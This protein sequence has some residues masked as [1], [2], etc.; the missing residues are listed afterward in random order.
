MKR[1]GIGGL[2]NFDA[3]LAT[4]QVVHKRLAY[5]T[6]E[7]KDAFRFAASEA[8]RLGLELAIAASPG[9]SETGGPWVKPSDGMKK[10]VWSELEV[11]GGRPLASRLLPPPA[12][13]GPYQDLPIGEAGSSAAGKPHFK[14]PEA[15][16]DVAVLAFPVMPATDDMPLAIE[17]AGGEAF[18]LA[19]L[20]DDSL[21][22]GVDIPASA[23]GKTSYLTLTYDRPTTFRS[24]ELFAVGGMSLF[25]HSLIAPRLERSDDGK[26]WLPVA[27][28]P[29]GPVP[30]TVGFAP[31]SARFFRV[32]FALAAPDQRSL[33]SPAPGADLS[34]VRYLAPPPRTTFRV[35]TLR[36]SSAAKIDQ[37]QSKAGFRTVPDYYK[38]SETVPDEDG[39]HLDNIINLSDRLKPDGSLDWLPPEGNWRIVRLGWSLVGT[40]NHPATLEATG[41]EVDKYDGEAVRRYL[42]H[43]LGMYKDTVGA[44]LIGQS[45]VRALLTDSIEVGPSNWTPRLIEQFK[46]LRGYDPTPYLPALAGY[47]VQSRADSDKFLYDFRR[48]LADLIASE[49]Y[50]TVAQVARDNGM[51]VYGE[52]LEWERPLIVTCPPLA[53]SI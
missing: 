50:G 21:T 27:E 48:T 40:T 30:T 5:M 20:N 33:G 53:P 49:H 23:E 35:G 42:N 39:I 11:V 36:L 6:P 44:N 16:G 17:G 29:V 46:K 28:I 7:W 10:L 2:Q 37:F 45:G 26:S 12:V 22:T 14:A 38:L 41:L 15:Y 52:A 43:Y 18:D 9:W 3:D 25:R 4:P 24:I 13:A 34:G 51:I 31:V 1:I 8:D 47:I 19:A 32:V